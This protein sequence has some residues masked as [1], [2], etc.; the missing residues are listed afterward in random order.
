MNLVW[1]K[2]S[3]EEHSKDRR[4]YT[5]EFDCKTCLLTRAPTCVSKKEIPKEKKMR[6]IVKKQRKK[7]EEISGERKIMNVS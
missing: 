6:E 7:K 1:N 2:A 5:H 3:E 4:H